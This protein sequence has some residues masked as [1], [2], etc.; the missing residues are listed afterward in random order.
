MRTVD[1]HLERIDRD[2]FS[3]IERAISEDEIRTIKDA[4]SPWLQGKRVGR[5]D[6]EGMHTER[7]YALLAK[8]PEIAKII[9]YPETLAIADRLLPKNY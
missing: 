9:E 2:G 4:L 3:V 6:F 5:N 7:V 1:H 8:A